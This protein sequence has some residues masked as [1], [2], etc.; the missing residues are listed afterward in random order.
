[1]YLQQKTNRTDNKLMHTIHP[2]SLPHIQRQ[3]NTTTP[4]I[5]RRVH[6]K[7]IKKNVHYP[8]RAGLLFYGSV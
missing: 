1:M 4:D 2:S 7:Y 6:R 5:S 8:V 3:I